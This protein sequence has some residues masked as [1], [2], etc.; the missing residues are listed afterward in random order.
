MDRQHGRHFTSLQPHFAA[1]LWRSHESI[2]LAHLAELQSGI[3]QLLAFESGRCRLFAFES[4]GSV[5]CGDES[6]VLAC[7]AQ[8]FADEPQLQPCQSSVHADF[9]GVLADVACYGGSRRWQ[10]IQSDVAGL[11]ADVAAVF[12]C[13]ACV[14]AHF[15]TV[16]AGVTSVLA[17]IAA[18]FTDE[19][20]D[21]DGRRVGGR[22]WSSCGI[23]ASQSHVKQAGLAALSVVG[24]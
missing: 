1:H 3:A 22:S 23:T 24:C 21:G 12:A 19:S 16:L 15:A 2:L 6:S 9:A 7:F 8:V 13:F 20:G 4:S 17:D 10:G 5:W 14:L 11:L 18:V